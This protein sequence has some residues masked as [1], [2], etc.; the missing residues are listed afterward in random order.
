MRDGTSAPQLAG[1]LVTRRNALKLAA[2]TVGAGIVS[3]QLPGSVRAREGSVAGPAGINA[4]L[5]NAGKG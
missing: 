1:R 5:D 4:C 2:L 3:T